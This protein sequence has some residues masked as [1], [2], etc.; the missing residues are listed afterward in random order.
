[1]VDLL[2]DCI[3]GIVMNSAEIHSASSS[4]GVQ[5]ASQFS[6]I[7]MFQHNFKFYREPVIYPADEPNPD[8]V[9]F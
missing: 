5:D 6:E 1:M 9:S 4:A 2:M 7:S 8:D 3:E